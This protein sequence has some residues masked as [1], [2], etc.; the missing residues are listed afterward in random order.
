[1]GLGP[2]GT[3][4][5]LPQRFG[6]TLR[7][8]SR[9]ERLIQNARTHASKQNHHVELAGEQALGEAEGFFVALER[10]FAHGRRDDGFA[11]LLANELGDF[12][13]APAL[14]RD[15]FETS[16]RHGAIIG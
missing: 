4:V 9:G 7:R 6:E 12:G 8:V 11:L 2:R 13:G 1:M 16:E 5:M 3:T 10:G 14:E 15:D